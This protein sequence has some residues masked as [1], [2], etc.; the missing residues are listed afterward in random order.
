MPSHRWYTIVEYGGMRRM[1]AEGAS[2]SAI[3]HAFGTNPNSVYTAVKHVPPPP[4]GWHKGG[5]RPRSNSSP[6]Q[7]ELFPS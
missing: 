7:I 6:D 5:R 1:R 3:A 2:L 4:G